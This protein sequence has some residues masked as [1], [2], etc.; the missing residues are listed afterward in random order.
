[1][2]TV[3]E[4]PTFLA[5]CRKAGLSEDDRD[6]IVDAIA[7]DPQGGDLIPGTG[8]ARKQRIAGRGKGKSGGYRVVSHYAGADLPALLL[9]LIDKGER[10]DLSQTGRNE[11]RKFLLTYASTYRSR[12]KH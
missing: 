6:A 5:D 12:R 10:A 8:G 7:E 3:I 1:M 2:I 4:M 9:H 11:I